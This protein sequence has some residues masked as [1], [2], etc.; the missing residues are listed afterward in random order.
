M[1]AR[2]R[3]LNPGHFGAAIALDARFGFSQA[4][5]SAV[6]TWE[7]RTNNNKDASQATA[8]NQPS[9][10]SNGL[11]GSPVVTFS[12]AN[13]P[14]EDYLDVASITV[15]QPI[16][17][18]AVWRANG[19]QNYLMDGTVSTGRVIIGLGLSTGA[20][21]KVEAYSGGAPTII[22]TVSM[23]GSDSIT[24]TLF[25]TTN[26][27]IWRDGVSRVTGTLGNT[28]IGSLRLGERYAN[29]GNVTQ[30]NGFI[31][32]FTALSTSSSSIRKRIEHSYG[33]SF[34]LACS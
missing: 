29:F 8:A 14:N 2:Q 12:G 32:S 21:G 31:G 25:D 23:T 22:D 26:S 7:D 11:N 13:V 28:N 33:Y 4:N 19:L 10:T 20:T 16:T 6:S 15:N 27:Q 9:Y 1:R 3:H 24:S 17:V 18:V 30:L 34:K 5:G